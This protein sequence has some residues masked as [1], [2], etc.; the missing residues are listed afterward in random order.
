MKANSNLVR[1]WKLESNKYIE[2]NVCS[3]YGATTKHRQQICLARCGLRCINA[4]CEHC[5]HFAVQKHVDWIGYR[6]NSGH[7]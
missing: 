7:N 3:Q 6:T 1:M 5:G 4:I 2:K